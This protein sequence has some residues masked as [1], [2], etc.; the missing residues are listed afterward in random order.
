MRKDASKEKLAHVHR[1]VCAIKNPLKTRFAIKV[2]GILTFQTLDHDFI[3]GPGSGMTWTVR[4][5]PKA[6]QITN[7][8]HL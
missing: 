4:K 1:D 8:L 7:D 5:A 3:P 2:D 6:E